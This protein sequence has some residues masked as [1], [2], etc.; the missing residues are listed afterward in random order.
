MKVLNYGYEE[1][2]V[3]WSTTSI[4][5]VQKVVDVRFDGVIVGVIR[6]AQGVRETYSE[7]IRWGRP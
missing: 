1:I 3:F 6:E 5:L 7:G 2:F 4:V